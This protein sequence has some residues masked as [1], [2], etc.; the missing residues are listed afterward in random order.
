[1]AFVVLL[2]VAVRAHPLAPSLLDV[3]ELQPGRLEVRWRTP[4]QRAPGS[5]L[6][7]L[8]PARC[9]VVAT[10]SP[11]LLG[12]ALEARWTL[13]CGGQS[14]IGTRLGASDIGSSRADVLLR[15]EL[16][17]GRRFQ[18]VLTPEAP[19]FEVPERQ[20][21]LAVARAYVA[22]GVSHIL[23]GWDHLLFV[24]GLVLLVK[25]GRRLVET[26][27]AF[28]LGHSVTLSLAVLGV[29]RVPQAPIEA[30]IAFSI[31]VVAWELGHETER[32]PTPLG[33][34][35]W[36]MAA[37]FGLLHGLGFA[38]AL[39]AAGL[40]VGEIP[41]ALASFNGG[42]ELGQLAFVLAVAAVRAALARLPWEWPE[43]ATLVPAYVIGS[44]AAFWLFDRTAPLLE[45]L[46]R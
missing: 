10:P 31:L 41:L 40:P 13:D 9:A 25:G 46:V 14:L 15:I 16:A 6:G 19:D 45:A 38:G 2:P 12:T 8:L 21:R 3:H 18:T 29:V 7:P 32:P 30:A 20:S 24:L 22:L 27:T 5:E 4:T 34:T 23:A 37:C 1:V 28:T 36:A 26:V 43:R 35:P 33:R 11:Q 44:L 39:A 17:D 42:I